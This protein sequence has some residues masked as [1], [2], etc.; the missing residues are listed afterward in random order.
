MQSQSLGRAAP[1]AGGARSGVRCSVG[2]PSTSPI[3]FESVYLV[4]A[5]PSAPFS[6]LLKWWTPLRNPPP[7]CRRLPRAT[8]RRI[9]S[10]TS[11]VCVG[12]RALQSSTRLAFSGA[13]TSL[14]SA[15]MEDSARSVDSP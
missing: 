10:A 13:S 3:I 7:P 6:L 11:T 9:T 2:L 1:P 15:V 12:K 4:C 14:A 8:T 5:R